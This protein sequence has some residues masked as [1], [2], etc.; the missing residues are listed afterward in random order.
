MIS[1]TS[2]HKPIIVTSPSATHF[3]HI[4]V[5]LDGSKLAELALPLARAFATQEGAEGKITI[6]G[7]DSRD[8]TAYA[9]GGAFELPPEEHAR[10]DN[11]LTTVKAKLR[12]KVSHVEHVRVSG[13]PATA[14]VDLAQ[15]RGADVIILVTHARS[16]L[17]KLIHGS[18]AERVLHLATVPVIVLKQRTATMLTKPVRFLVPLDGSPLAESVLPLVQALAVQ[19]SAPVTLLRSLDLPD[20]EATGLG[21]AGA[22][23]A[24]I[25]A[26]IPAARQEA[27]GYL[28]QIQEQFMDKGIVTELVVTEGE[29]AEDISK[30]AATLEEHKQATVLIAMSTHGRSGLTRWLYGSVTGVLLHLTES[31]MLVVRAR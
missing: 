14:I 15:E 31:P 2:S 27:L 5:P 1:P 24:S 6:L 11:Y 8:Y 28:A 4:L 25:R 3:R 7:V 17:G 16:G 20:L 19:L 13:D 21:R 10:L 29:A 30:Q 9:R 26:S 12:T 18:V 23:T 22:A